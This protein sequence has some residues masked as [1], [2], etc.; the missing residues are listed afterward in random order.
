MG[1]LFWLSLDAAHPLSERET[2]AERLSSHLI[3]LSLVSQLVKETSFYFIHARH[4]APFAGTAP[5][6]KT[7]RRASLGFI[8]NVVSLPWVAAAAVMS[9]PHL[10]AAAGHLRGER[11]GEGYEGM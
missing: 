5:P 2:L 6:D 1:G 10:T 4:A 3:P 9:C 7:P 11:E 8:V